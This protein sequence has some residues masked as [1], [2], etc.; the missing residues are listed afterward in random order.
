MTNERPSGAI[1]AC[2]PDG[3]NQSEYYHERQREKPCISASCRVAGRCCR[4]AVQ[5]PTRASVTACT[6]VPQLSRF[7]LSIVIKFPKSTFSSHRDDYCIVLR[8]RGAQRSPIRHTLACLKF[9]SRH[10]CH[11]RHACLMTQFLNIIWE[12]DVIV[13]Q[14]PTVVRHGSVNFN[15]PPLLQLTRIK[16]V[17]NVFSVSSV[18]IDPH[19]PSHHQVPIGADSGWQLP[20]TKHVQSTQS[21]ITPLWSVLFVLQGSLHLSAVRQPDTVISTQGCAT[22]QNP[23]SDYK[24]PMTSPALVHLHL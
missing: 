7:C 6:C 21:K 10:R 12:T 14:Y 17:I 4:N 2:S 13:W 18:T 3:V 22:T 8:R 15:S 20:R 5:S 9:T 24:V 1:G 19:P 23:G 16:L 11:V